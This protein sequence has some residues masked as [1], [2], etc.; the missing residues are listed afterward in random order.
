MFTVLFFTGMRLG[1]VL[2][3]SVG[4][5]VQKELDD[6]KLSKILAQYN[7]RSLG[8]IR[9]KSQ[10][11]FIEDGVVNRKPLKTKTTMT[12]EDGRFIPIVDENCFKV[13][14]EL[15]RQAISRN[16]T[17][18]TDYLKSGNVLYFDF[19]S[20]GTAY[21]KLNQVYEILRKRK[22]VTKWKPWHCNRHSRST[23]L[24][25]ETF[26]SEIIK[27]ILGHSSRQYET[28]VHLAGEVLENE[29]D[30]KYI[31]GFGDGDKI[32]GEN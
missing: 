2:G 32:S 12:Y 7:I 30:D 3:L 1:E 28:Y 25:K 26:N 9:L 21:Y 19:I 18:T 14:K 13:L 31:L 6:K 10:L 8:Y 17:K 4:D 15:N 22:V 27:L 5:F 11:D 23:E 20:K 29:V 24:T 16:K